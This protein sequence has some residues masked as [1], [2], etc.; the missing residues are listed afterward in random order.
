MPPGLASKLMSWDGE[1]LAGHLIAFQRSACSVLPSSPSGAGAIIVA[2]VGAFYVRPA[3][4]T[5][6]RLISF[7]LKIR[8]LLLINWFKMSQNL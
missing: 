6:F 4:H 5:D 1:S 8:L 3:Y 2:L 7:G